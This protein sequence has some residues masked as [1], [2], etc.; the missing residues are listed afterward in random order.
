[1]YE[2]LRSFLGKFGPLP[3]DDWLFLIS[4]AGLKK[5]RK[6]EILLRQGDVETNLYF[7]L[8]GSVRIAQRVENKDVT[9]NIFTEG[10][11][12][13]ESISL[14]TG[15]PTELTVD[16]LEDSLVILI[17]MKHMN[18]ATEK[19]PALSMIMHRITQ[20]IVVFLARRTLDSYRSGTDRYLDLLKTKPGIFKRV[21]KYVIASYLGLTPEAFSRI[22]KSLK[23]ES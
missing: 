21:P 5:L 19:S 20:Q 4:R 22:V 1:M 18:A 23:S 16:T 6:N 17:P 10:D 2:P 12:F 13:S 7:L 9:R 8:E 11:F 15:K 3:E 14:F